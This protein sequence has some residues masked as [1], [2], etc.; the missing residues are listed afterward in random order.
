M[1]KIAQVEP[2]LDKPAAAAAADQHLT[3]TA[4]APSETAAGVSR[5]FARTAT[6]VADDQK[7]AARHVA[8]EA[9]DLGRTAAELLAEQARHGVDAA[10]AMGRAVDWAQLA[11]AQ[12]DF[13]AGSFERMRQ[14]NDRCR[15]AMLSGVKS[16]SFSARR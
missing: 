2:T 5:E 4:R 12:R 9:G 7:A 13:F 6:A 8:S 11:Q 16:M 10:A 14:F 15:E 3:R 1:S